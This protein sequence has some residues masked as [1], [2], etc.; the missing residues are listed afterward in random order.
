ME[1][2]QL[3]APWRMSYIEQL[4]EDAS[5]A[6]SESGTPACFLCEAIAAPCGGDDAAQRLV[7]HADEHGLL[8]L[9]RYPYTNGHLL[10]APRQHVPDLGD[11]TPAARAGLMELTVLGQRVL[12]A[13]M[14]PQGLNIGVNLGRCAGAGL[15]G[16]VHLHIVPRW[17][18]DTNFM[19]I[20][21]QVRV[22]PQALE[23][24]YQLLRKAME[25]LA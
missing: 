5:P 15:P 24:S 25:G 11:L 22:I 10:V 3:W 8:L 13:A 23:A 4:V 20:V 1:H 14:N 7:L 18:G 9:N 19:Q 6:P 16:H 2:K 21:G 12:R 17:N